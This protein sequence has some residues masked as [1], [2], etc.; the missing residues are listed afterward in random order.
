[1]AYGDKLN[2]YFINDLIKGSPAEKAGLQVDDEVIALN[3]SPA[4]LY[5]LT[6]VNSILKRNKGERLRLI[7]RRDGNLIQ[8]V[9]KHQRLL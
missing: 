6:E 2:V 1:M 8:F 7:I 5:D 4:F 3:G 9:L